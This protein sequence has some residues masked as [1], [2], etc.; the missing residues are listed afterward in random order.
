M[1][2]KLP[3]KEIASHLAVHIERDIQ[4]SESVFDKDGRGN[5]TFR[6]PQTGKLFGCSDQHQNV[7]KVLSLFLSFFCVF[8][9]K[10]Y[11][12]EIF[13]FFLLHRRTLDERVQPK[14]QAKKTS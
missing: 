12:R 13:H 4:K 3:K 9:Q 7:I 5:V 10:K 2:I 11:S 8:I 14:S 6:R 1:N